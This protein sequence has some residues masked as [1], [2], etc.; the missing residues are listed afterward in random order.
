M[1]LPRAEP[2]IQRQRQQ[3][4]Q[5]QL[6]AYAI[7]SLGE[8]EQ[9][10]QKVTHRNPPDRRIAGPFPARRISS[11]SGRGFLFPSAA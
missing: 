4:E 6:P 2:S 11:P 3:G 9:K 10:K 1:T 8:Q 7:D 5:D